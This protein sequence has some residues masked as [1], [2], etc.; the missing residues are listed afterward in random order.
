MLLQPEKAGLGGSIPSLA[1]IIPKVRPG[2]MG[3][4]PGEATIYEAHTL[5]FGGP[6]HPPR[7]PGWRPLA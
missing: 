3:L 6:L 7:G 5:D 2:H 4:A 1:T